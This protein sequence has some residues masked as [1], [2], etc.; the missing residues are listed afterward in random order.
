VRNLT[1][2]VLGKRQFQRLPNQLVELVELEQQVAMALLM[3][4]E[5]LAVLGVTE[6]IHLFTQLGAEPVEVEELWKIL[7]FQPPL[8]VVEDH[9][10]PMDVAVTVESGLMMLGRHSQLLVEVAM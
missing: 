9:M 2:P 5:L 4:M 3:V 7:L 8:K 6:L 1:I 10:A